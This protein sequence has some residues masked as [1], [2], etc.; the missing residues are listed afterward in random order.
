MNLSVGACKRADRLVTTDPRYLS[1][2]PWTRAPRPYVDLHIRPIKS[3]S[4]VVPDPESRRST[5]RYMDIF[6]ANSNDS[7]WPKLPASLDSNF[8]NLC[9]ATSID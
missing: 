4:T 8:P 5:V 9:G 6:E 3:C 1:M 2:N 7:S